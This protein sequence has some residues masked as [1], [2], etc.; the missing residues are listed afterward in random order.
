MCANVSPTSVLIRMI[1]STCGR[2]NL[3]TSCWEYEARDCSLVDEGNDEMVNRRS[4][5]KT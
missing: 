4:E 5:G 2:T 1:L 3:A